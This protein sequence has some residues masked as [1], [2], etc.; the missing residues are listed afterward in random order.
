M[1]LIL[2][3]AACQTG[4][5]GGSVVGWVRSPE[6]VIFR[7]DVSGS[8]DPWE[9]NSGV[10]YCAVYGDNR[11]VWTNN[12]SDGQYEVLY[13]RVSDE[14][15]SRFVE[16]LTVTERIYTYQSP[17][18]TDLPDETAPILPLVYIDVNGLAHTADET[19]GWPPDWYAR[20]TQLCTGISQTPV[21]FLPTEGWLV[22][23][24]TQ[25]LPD[26]PR[27][28]WTDARVVL[29]EIAADGGARWVTGEVVSLVWSGMTTMP[30]SLVYGENSRFFRV[31]LQVPGITRQSPPA[32][33][34]QEQ[35]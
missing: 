32:P 9:F 2:L 3:L 18:Q 12:L 15:I 11:V 10:P 6:H 23:Q 24:E 25:A 4:G 5:G 31:A 22:V 27:W 1:G 33:E 16:R 34:G 19:S 35:G 17:E 30:P 13:D 28:T 21:L 8:E 7:A 14:A 26:A 29:S 20:I